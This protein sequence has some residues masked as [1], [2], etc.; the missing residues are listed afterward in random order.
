MSQGHSHGH[1]PHCKP[2]VPAQAWPRSTHMGPALPSRCPALSLRN[3][4]AQSH[5]RLIGACSADSGRRRA[6]AH[7]G[8]ATLSCTQTAK[9]GQEHTEPGGL[10]STQKHLGSSLGYEI[11]AHLYIIMGSEEK[12]HSN[13]G[14]PH[15]AVF[16]RWNFTLCSSDYKGQPCLLT[17]KS[18][19]KRN[20]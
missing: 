2:R 11:Q 7:Q 13:T 3:A 10:F 14:N 18:Q 12:V 6:R 19:Q 8:K 20:G 4:A 17:L 5:S 1:Q 15:H 16:R 9:Q